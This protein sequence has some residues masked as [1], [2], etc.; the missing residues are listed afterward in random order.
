[1]KNS[2]VKT[3]AFNNL[4]ANRMVE[5]PFILSS[6]IMF[7]LFNIM[8]SL[9]DNDYVIHLSLIHISEPTRLL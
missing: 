7:I 4:K 3:F 6:S 1:M 5:T 8:S 9:S 2:T